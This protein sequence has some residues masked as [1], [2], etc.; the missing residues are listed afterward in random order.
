M[1][2]LCRG[3][4]GNKVDFD[5]SKYAAGVYYIKIEEKGKTITKK[6]VKQ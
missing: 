3:T 6:V 2:H 4:K 1:T 5:L